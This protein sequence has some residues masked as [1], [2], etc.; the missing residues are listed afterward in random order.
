MG[1]KEFWP[2]HAT[3]GL[4]P[5][6]EFKIPKPPKVCENAD[7]VLA[8]NVAWRKRRGLEPLML[9]TKRLWLPAGEGLG[10]VELVKVTDV[11]SGQSIDVASVRR[12]GYIHGWSERIVRLMLT[13][14]D[15]WVSVKEMCAFEDDMSARAMAAYNAHAATQ[16]ARFQ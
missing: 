10:K 4:K 6:P 9:L 3:D 7:A 1:P 11:P 16:V 5:R 12:L 15:T 14:P 13:I 2:V 8:D